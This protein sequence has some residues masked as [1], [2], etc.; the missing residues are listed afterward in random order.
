MPTDNPSR[1]SRQQHADI[2]AYVL[3]VN[4]FPSGKTEMEPKTEV[5]RGVTFEAEK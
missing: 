4:R 1:V 2:L 5:L 3:S